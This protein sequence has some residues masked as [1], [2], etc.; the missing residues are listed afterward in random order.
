MVSGRGASL[1][2]DPLSS[3]STSSVVVDT[4]GIARHLN[5]KQTHT[6]KRDPLSSVRERVDWRS[7]VGREP[8]CVSQTL[9][10][11]QPQTIGRRAP[12]STRARGSSDA[13]DHRSR[14]ARD[15]HPRGAESSFRHPRGAELSFGLCP[16]G[17]LVT[18][19][20]RN[21]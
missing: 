13:S 17:S 19:L 1:K 10:R 4:L 18:H 16:W 12:V 8:T 15:R 7:G 14:R 21:L 11:A 3:S 9:S 5:L 20:P 2:R 6:Q